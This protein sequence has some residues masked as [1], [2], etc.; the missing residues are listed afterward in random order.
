MEM[1]IQKRGRESDS[2][3]SVKRA[4]HESEVNIERRRG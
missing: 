1:S 2:S 4:T 3:G